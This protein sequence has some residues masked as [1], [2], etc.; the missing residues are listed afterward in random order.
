MTDSHA[1]ALTGIQRCIGS[2][3]SGIRG[4]YGFGELRFRPPFPS[5]GRVALEWSS[6]VNPGDTFSNYVGEVRKAGYYIEHPS[7]WGTPAVANVIE[8]LM[9]EGK[10][11]YRLP[12]FIR[13]DII[14]SIIQRDTRDNDSE[15]LYYHS[16]LYA[17]RVHSESPPLRRASRNDAHTGSAPMEDIALIGI[18]GHS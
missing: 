9:R 2:V 7:P 10:S 18:R 3:A 17:L 12:N 11:G 13:S 5:R 14:S 8:A 15:H 1:I 6:I 4:C 16:F